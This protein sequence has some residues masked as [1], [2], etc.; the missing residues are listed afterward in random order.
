MRGACSGFYSCYNRKGG[1]RVEWREAIGSIT[2]LSS[3]FGLFLQNLTP[4]PV[5]LLLTTS[6]TTSCFKPPSLE[7]YCPDNCTTQPFSIA[8]SACCSDHGSPMCKTLLWFPIAL[9]IKYLQTTMTC[10][11][12]SSPPQPLWP[13]SNSQA[14]K[15]PSHLKTFDLAIPSDWIL[16]CFSILCSHVT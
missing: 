15:S 14:S 8:S 5:C 1:Y 12:T 3:P 7:S 13:S 16:F 10:I 11:P 9:G 2:N 6:I 4:L